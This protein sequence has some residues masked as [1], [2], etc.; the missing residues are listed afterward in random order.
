MATRIDLTGQRF[1]RLTVVSFAGIK[2][3]GAMWDCVCDCGNHTVVA[4]SNLRKKKKPTVSCGCYGRERWEAAKTKKIDL[5]GERFGRL[6]VL[7]QVDSA[8]S[9]SRYECLCD[10]GNKTIVYG[11]NLRRGYTQSCGCYRHEC[12]KVNT[13]THGREPRRIYRIWSGML[14]RCNNPNNG[15]YKHYGG[16]G[17]TVC[18]EWHDFTA[19][20][21]WALSHGYREDLSID[22]IN[23]DGNYEPDNCRWA[24][25]K[26]QAQN[27][28]P[29]TGRV[30]QWR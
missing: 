18:G 16:R 24:T 10:C 11:N 6:V 28:R 1:G 23:N 26:E 19:F 14:N 17:I 25:A 21:D 7:R 20:R 15:R 29:R 9:M 5:T 3:K 13:R 4:G 2:N 8:N 22:R 27:K 30:N 12:E